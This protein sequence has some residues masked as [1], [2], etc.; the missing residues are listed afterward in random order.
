MELGP[1]IAPWIEIDHTAPMLF[2]IEKGELIAL[3][4]A[5]LRPCSSE[6]KKAI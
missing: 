1:V 4:P 2:R 3:K 5:T 6:L